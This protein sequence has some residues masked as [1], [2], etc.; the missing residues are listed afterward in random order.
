[1]K[2]ILAILALISLAACENLD[3]VLDTYEGM[4]ANAQI[5]R[6]IRQ[7]EKQQQEIQQKARQAKTPADWAALLP[8]KSAV[9]AAIKN[10]PAVPVWHDKD[11]KLGEGEQTIHTSYGRYIKTVIRNGIM[12]NYADVYEADGTLQSHTPLVNGIPQGWSDGYI[13]TTGVRTRLYYQDGKI[14]RWQRYAP[15]GQ[16]IDEDTV[17]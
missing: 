15:D 13:A 8:P 12:D 17:P 2:I 16:L 10:K 3:T 4:Y 9:N 7:A 11:L 1:M 5:N 14:T 6:H